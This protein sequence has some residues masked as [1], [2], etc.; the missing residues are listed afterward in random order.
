MLRSE[1]GDESQDGGL[2]G[3]R[4]PGD[5]GDGAGHR[6]EPVNPYAGVPNPELCVPDDKRQAAVEPWLVRCPAPET[7]QLQSCGNPPGVLQGALQYGDQGAGAEAFAPQPERQAHG[8][9]GVGQ[10]GEGRPCHHQHPGHA[11]QR[12]AAGQPHEAAGHINPRVEQAEAEDGCGDGQ[13]GQ[14]R[15]PEA[16]R[17]DRTEEDYMGIRG[18]K[19]QRRQVEQDRA[20]GARPIEK[21]AVNDPRRDE[22]SGEDC[23]CAQRRGPEGH[24][25]GAAG[26]PSTVKSSSRLSPGLTF[27]VARPS[28]A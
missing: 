3:T 17:G 18:G 1:T 24:A 23:R 6:R 13:G 2:S 8:G 26:S 25:A 11:L 27:K 16:R 21:D 4:G 5:H 10:G 20:A 22:H 14:R 9:D 15:L 28:C 19:P 12:A 7:A